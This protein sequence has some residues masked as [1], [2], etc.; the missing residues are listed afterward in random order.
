MD[1]YFEEQLT[2]LGFADD[3]HELMAEEAFTYFQD[4][5]STTHEELDSMISGFIKRQNYPIAITIKR[6]KL[7]HD[8][9]NWSGDFYCRGME[10]ATTWPGEEINT[11]ED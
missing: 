8:L 2:F 6:W 1:D 10:T 9:R 3:E 7:L 5:L 4:F 11:E